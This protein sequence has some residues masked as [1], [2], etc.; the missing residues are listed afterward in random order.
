M[1]LE[2]SDGNENNSRN[3]SP[4]GLGSLQAK[5]KGTQLSDNQSAFTNNNQR[6][7]IRTANGNLFL[8]YESMGEVWLEMST[9]NGRT[10][11]FVNYYVMGIGSP[12]LVL[13]GEGGFI[14][15]RG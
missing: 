13:D 3:V 11:D 9:D 1:F 14:R 10:W 7:M 5:Y 12:S 4:T 8:T 15:I 2:W 6:K